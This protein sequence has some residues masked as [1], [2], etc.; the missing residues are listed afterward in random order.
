VHDY[1][2]V[3][4]VCL[5]PSCLSSA[6]FLQYQEQMITFY[7]V[8]LRMALYTAGLAVQSAR[9]SSEHDRS[10]ASGCVSDCSEDGLKSIKQEAVSDTAA[11]AASSSIASGSASGSCDSPKPLVTAPA[12]APIGTVPAAASTAATA[13]AAAAATAAGA[14]TTATYSVAAAVQELQRLRIFKQCVQQCLT[15]SETAEQQLET[16]Q[17][18]A[19]AATQAAPLVASATAAATAAAAAVTQ[20]GGAALTEA[21]AAELK[22]LQQMR[23]FVLQALHSSTDA[24]S[25]VTRIAFVVPA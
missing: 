25:T 2:E 19:T 5:K 24:V 9:T 1:T 20:H 14:G 22:Q 15:S 3:L 11:A 10:D 23:K 8:L 12:S 16:L 21:A 7:N 18:V 4:C 17:F 13:A 6:P